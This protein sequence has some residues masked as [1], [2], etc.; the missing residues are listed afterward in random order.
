MAVQTETQTNI[1]TDRQKYKDELSFSKKK[2]YHQRFFF[3]EKFFFRLVPIVVGCHDSRQS[4]ISFNRWRSKIKSDFT[5]KSEIWILTVEVGLSKNS[6]T[7]TFIELWNSTMLDLQL[8]T[9][10]Q[11]NIHLDFG[12]SDS[13]KSKLK[14]QDAYCI[15]KQRY[16]GKYFVWIWC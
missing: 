8:D 6:N 1:K 9:I 10:L 2:K 13:F 5:E 16:V 3:Q 7:K 14:H 12:I 4:I 11:K 15:V